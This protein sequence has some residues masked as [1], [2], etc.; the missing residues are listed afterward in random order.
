MP[1]AAKNHQDKFQQW[2]K[3]SSKTIQEEPK[4]KKQN[5]LQQKL[6]AMPKKKQK[7]TFESPAMRQNGGQNISKAIKDKPEVMSR[8]EQNYLQRTGLYAKDR[9]Q[10][11]R[12]RVPEMAK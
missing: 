4:N 1:K 2:P 5:Y 7:K 10:T 9:M 6:R 11:I 3:R 12:K 8:H